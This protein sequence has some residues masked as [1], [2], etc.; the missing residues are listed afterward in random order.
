MVRGV[1]Y[2]VYLIAH[3]A[4]SVLSASPSELSTDQT[5][6]ITSYSGH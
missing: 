2:V 6:H 1:R 3:H 5:I 4:N